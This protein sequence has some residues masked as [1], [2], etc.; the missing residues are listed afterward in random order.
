MVSKLLER[1]LNN[2]GRSRTKK[3]LEGQENFQNLMRI[4]SLR[5]LRKS[6]KD[7]A[8][9]L[10]ASSGC[11]ID[12]S[13]VRRSL[14]RNGLC[15]R[16]ATK[17]PLFWKGNRLIGMKISGKECYGETNPSLIFWGPNIDNM[18]G[19]ELEKDG[20]I[21]ASGLQWNMGEGLCWFLAA[22]LPVVLAI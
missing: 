13:T 2:Q 15:G 11:Q 9:H 3:G 8:Q 10:A 21:Y 17:K 4:S 6:N 16:V 18:W 19:E 5:N 1:N 7:I 12:P 14:I 22:F 20:K